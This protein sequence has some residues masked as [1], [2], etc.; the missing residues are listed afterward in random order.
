MPFARYLAASSMLYFQLATRIRSRVE[1]RLLSLTPVS[2]FGFFGPSLESHERAKFFTGQARVDLSSSGIEQADAALCA[3]QFASL[4]ALPQHPGRHAAEVLHNR[5][6][7]RIDEHCVHLFGQVEQH[8]L[9]DQEP[10]GA[11]AHHKDVGADPL[12]VHTDSGAQPAEEHAARPQH[13]P[14][15]GQ[16]GAEMLF[17]AS[18]MK[19]RIADHH[20]GQSV[21]EGHLLNQSCLKVIRRQASRK[22]RRKLTKMLDR[23]GRFIDRKDLAALA[24]EMHEISSI[25]AAGIENP[26]VRGDVSSQDLIE[27]VNIDLPELFLNA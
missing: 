16:H 5:R 25:S 13:P 19:D 7:E 2:R 11:I 3:E 9:V 24:Q 4:H 12:E 8:L 27:D 21:R 17:V 6:L 22:R 18:K 26:H 20:I 14:E 10:P 23:L 15:F 1:P